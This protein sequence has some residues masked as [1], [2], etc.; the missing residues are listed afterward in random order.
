[1]ARDLMK[2]VFAA[3]LG[4][5]MV[6]GCVQAKAEISISDDDHITVSAR[7]MVEQSQARYLDREV[8]AEDICDSLA[9]ELPSAAT[10]PVYEPGQVGCEARATVRLAQLSS[11]VWHTGDVYEVRVPAYPGLQASQLASIRVAVQF[12]GRVIA[13]SGKP[14]RQGSRGLVWT[15]KEDYLNGMVAAQ[16]QDRYQGTPWWVI[17]LGAGVFIA[18]S[19]ILI[20]V[21]R[22]YARKNPA[23]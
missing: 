2:R 9:A 4:V 10:V 19:G 1:M 15:E 13:Y 16:G 8:R 6:S 18:A 14:Q 3:L 7:V 17:V 20:V 22:S 12:P 5:L 23:R 11:Y 21:R